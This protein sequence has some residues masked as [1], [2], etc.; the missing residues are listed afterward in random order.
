MK[1]FDVI[2]IGAGPAGLL[3]SKELSKKHKVLILEKNKIGE[4]NKNWLTYRDRWEGE[5]F[6]GGFIENEFKEW[7]VNFVGEDIKNNFVI[8]DDIVCFNE[9]KFLKYLAD[10]SKKQGAEIRE[11][12]EF[13]SFE[14]IDDRLIVNGKFKT[15]LL[16][17]CSGINSKIV[18]DYDLVDLPMYINCYSYLAKF[19]KVENKNY[20]S[21]FFDKK[22][23]TYACFGFT[24]VAPKIAQLQY[25]RRSNEK[26][27]LKD[28]RTG[29][30]EA[31]KR[32]AIPKHKIVE[33]KV[34]SYPTGIIKKRTM[35]NIFLFGDSG[36]Y[37]SASNGM[38][39]NEILRQYKRVAR[40]LSSCI[41]GDLLR[42][43]DLKIPSDVVNDINNIFMKIMCL[44][45]DNA[46]SRVTDKAFSV[47][48]ELNQ[49]EINNYMR[50][51]VSNKQALKILRKIVFSIG[52]WR[53]IKTLTK[54]YP[55]YIFGLLF[56]L[57]WKIFIKGI[58]S[59]FYGKDKYLM[60]DVYD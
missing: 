44:T 13:K 3:L 8:R 11:G 4:T 46:S 19:D 39:F 10:I 26:M 28:Y 1:E 57:F 20:Y 6:P 30:K 16:I 34:A 51:T 25:F 54:K 42:E 47:F 14:R 29:M 50:N 59:V 58:G 22:R 9:N 12:A 33:M 5:G 27:N 24:K 60:N 45:S 56:L 23:E 32:F 17:D 37:A 48:G 40:H 49:T 41:G 21:Y 43:K 2:I 52:F 7:S 55:R 31:Q 38:G 36:F 15:K 53:T 18:K 35:N